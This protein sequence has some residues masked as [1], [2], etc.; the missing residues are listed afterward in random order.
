MVGR[1]VVVVVAT[2][3]QKQVSGIADWACFGHEIRFVG[4]NTISDLLKLWYAIWGLN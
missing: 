1:S 3:F 4:L 2:P